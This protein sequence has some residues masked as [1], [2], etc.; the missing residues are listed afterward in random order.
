M[1]PVR[2]V[3]CTPT[4]LAIAPSGREVGFAL[5][6]SERLLDQF[7]LNVRKL[8]SASGRE[9][10]FGAQ[11]G[12]IL[13]E[14]RVTTIAVVTQ[15]PK[16]TNATMD[17]QLALIESEAGRRGIAIEKRLAQH[18][19]AKAMV[20]A[21]AGLATNLAV[22]HAAIE[23]FPELAS[24]LDEEAGSRER[25]G[26]DRYHSRLFLAV[27]CGVLVLEEQVLARLESNLPV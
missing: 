15:K 23:L 16:D 8:P 18:V 1:R 27:L 11:I 21:K 24:R 26:K 7:V 5:V 3:P 20:R 12:E 19:R 4:C 13:D 2:R 9:Q 17:A 10:K 14:G 6:T 25:N 22:A